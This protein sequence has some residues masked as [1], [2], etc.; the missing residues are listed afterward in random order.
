[1]S[2]LKNK[3]LIIRNSRNT[4]TYGI[5]TSGEVELSDIAPTLTMVAGSMI[6][7]LLILIVEKKYYSF[8]IRSKNKLLIK[9]SN[10]NLDIRNRLQKGNNNKNL[11]LQE[12]NNMRL[13]GYWP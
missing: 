4:I 12:F 13:I 7:A 8:K 11:K 1:M 2:K 6:L 3:H 5:N 10:Y 9:K